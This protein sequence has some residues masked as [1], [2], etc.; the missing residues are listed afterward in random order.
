ME[1]HRHKVFFIDKWQVS[2]LEG[3]L[4][5]GS[6][7]VRLEPKAMEVLV[8]FASRP[9]EVITRHELERDVW[10]GALV[11]YD[12]VTN[13]VIKL[14]KALQDSAREPR[15]IVTIPKKGY[16]LI[17]STDY[18]G[19]DDRP[20]SATP[21]SDVPKAAVRRDWPSWSFYRTGIATAVLACILVFVLLWLWS[22][23]NKSVALPSIVVLPFDNLNEDPKQDYLANGIT[24][25]II[26]DLS[27]LS[28]ILVIASNTSS[29]YRGKHVSAED[30]GA[31]LNVEFVLRGSI[32]RLGDE[33]RVNVQLINTE[34][35][36]NTW[37]Q[38]YDRKIAEVFAVQDE[39]T[40]SIVKALAVKI[41]NQE[42]HRLVQKT[43]DSLKAYDYFQEG[44][45]IYKFSTK[46]TNEQARE[47]YR[48]AIELD[49]SYGRAYGAMAITLAR[50]YR[51]G[52]TNTPNEALDRA[53]VL[54]KTAVALD[55]A[56]PQTYWALGF[57]YFTRKDFLNAE[58]AAARSITIA[59]SYADGYGLLALISSH[60]GQPKRAMELTN[61][62]IR[63]NPYFTW[64]YLYV[65]GITKYATGSY[66]SAIALL[67][68]AQARNDN[69]VPVKLFLAACYVKANRQA[70]AEWVVAQ[71]QMLSPA[72]TVTAIDKTIPIANPEF[73]QSFL[74]DLRKAGLPE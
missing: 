48:K 17:A 62:G 43:T 57:V 7:T 25:D 49:P 12:A 50:D 54:A 26:T 23:N 3:L 20:E 11:G 61:M 71:L 65:L 5:R 46:E 39:V 34:T 27:K 19:G 16:Q 53:L 55:N 73:K 64:E 41:T 22:T 29:R 72:T 13:T 18:H 30:V 56:S 14:R 51:R 4:T 33:V 1:N 28:N 70:D 68:K 66:D 44:Q 10:H 52:W 15:F 9:G 31:D 45:R 24:E 32:R 8:Y 60:N 38:R 47:L 2:P 21:V 42:E 74:K 6:E 58:K 40:R 35:G 37:A 69:V 59:P 36:F 67:E 63:L